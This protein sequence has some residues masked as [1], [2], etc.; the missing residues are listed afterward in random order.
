VLAHF[1]HIANVIVNANHGACLLIPGPPQF[2][3]QF[4]ATNA[5][6]FLLTNRHVLTST[7][8]GRIAD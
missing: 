3:T 8:M 2:V 1:D 5:A 7:L 6:G 4:L